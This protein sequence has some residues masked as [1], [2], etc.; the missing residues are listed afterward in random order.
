P[1]VHLSILPDSANIYTKFSFSAAKSYDDEDS[2][3]LL[4]FRWDFDGDGTW[5]TDF[6]Q[7]SAILH[8]YLMVGKYNAGVEV[9]DPTNRSSMLRKLVTVDLL[10][11]SIL[12][13]FTAD[14]GF[15]TVADIF[16][17]DAS[18]SKFLD[19]EDK[20]LTYS[21]DIYND[22]LW[23]AIDLPSPYFK[24]V[25]KQEGNVKVKL[26]VSDDRGLYM[27]TINT[28]EVFP[29][30]SPPQAVLVVGSKVGNFQTNFFFH[31]YGTRDRETSI[32]DLKYQW[33]VN[34]DGQWEPEFNNLQEIFYQFNK[35]GKHLVRLKVIDAHEDSAIASDTV[36]IY[37][38]QH[39][40]GLLVDKRRYPSD[41]Y[42]IV[43][44]GNLWWMQE[45][46]RIEI[47][48]GSGGGKPPGILRGCYGGDPTLCDRYGGLYLY[49]YGK[50][51]CPKGWRLPTKAEFQE[52]VNLEAPNSLAPLLLG[53]SSELHFL[54]SGY[55]DTEHHSVGFGTVAQFWLADL[56][57]SGF[58]Y[59][60]YIDKAKGE[61][62]PAMTSQTY[63]YSV[64]C[65]KSD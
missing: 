61:N 30:N 2:S 5:D 65:V 45:N 24:R 51:G 16:Q 8:Q 33:D 48:P 40:T 63:Y 54:M 10:N 4:T 35:T 7:N 37:A 43:R 18:G 49:G 27:D 58:P 14:G 52:M 53:G 23:E 6:N 41:Y 22:N 20:K 17:F 34:G 13:Q 44:I 36:F 28:I 31:S 64:R 9:K 62:R 26:R 47:E 11:D 38:G 3:N 46:L 57:T 42:G 21:W 12:P 59:V 55:I 1:I 29:E 39:E 56:T 60:W 19:R 50:N 32:L 25:I 15:S